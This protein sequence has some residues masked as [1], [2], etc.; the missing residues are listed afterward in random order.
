MPA[1]GSSEG[2]V[3]LESGD[4]SVLA[5]GI[6]WERPVHYGPKT[7][8]DEIVVDAEVGLGEIRVLTAKA[9]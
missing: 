3:N 1:T 9:S 5:G 6:S 7:G 4:S 8:A 2:S